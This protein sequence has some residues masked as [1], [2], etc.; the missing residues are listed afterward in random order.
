MNEAEK[1]DAAFEDPVLTQTR[2]S[3]AYVARGVNL[4][5]LKG[6]IDIEH[7]TNI[8]VSPKGLRLI[9]ELQFTEEELRSSFQAMI[10][11]G[12]LNDKLYYDM[13]FDGVLSRGETLH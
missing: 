1:L 2:G 9:G 3:I 11:K 10:V 7:A 5:V 8:T 12:Y 6:M 4:C 13:A